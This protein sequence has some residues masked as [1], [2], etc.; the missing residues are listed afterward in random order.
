MVSSL[1]PIAYTHIPYAKKGLR[2]CQ[3]Q[4]MNKL[5]TLLNRLLLYAVWH[6]TTEYIA[7]LFDINY[8]NEYEHCTMPISSSAGHRFLQISSSYIHFPLIGNAETNIIHTQKFKKPLIPLMYV[9]VCTVKV[10]Y[11]SGLVCGNR[12]P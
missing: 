1:V 2:N 11:P 5:E 9:N 3:Q 8:L 6:T 4:N 10:N 12:Q 7:S